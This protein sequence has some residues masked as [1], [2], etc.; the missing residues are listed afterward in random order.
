MQAGSPS[1]HPTTT[2]SPEGQVGEAGAV[3]VMTEIKYELPALIIEL[4]YRVS[5]EKAFS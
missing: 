4:G 3:K 2:S 1:P 5:L